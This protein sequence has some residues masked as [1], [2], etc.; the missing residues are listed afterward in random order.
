ML[1]VFM[2]IAIVLSV[3]SNIIL[4]SYKNRDFKT[5]GDVFLFNSGIS[6]VWLVVLIIWSLISGDF[7][8]SRGS[9]FFGVIYGVT[10]ALFLYFKTQSMSTGPVALTSLISNCAFLVATGFGVVYADEIVKPLQGVGMG[11]ILISLLLC[12]NPKKSE[13]KLTLKWFIYCFA[14]F[15]AGGFIGI[16]YKI[17]NK[18]DAAQEVNSMM[19]TAAIVSSVLFAVFGFIING[20]TKQQAKPKVYKKS[21]IYMLLRGIAGCIYIRMN[22]SL[23]GQIPSVIFFPVSNGANVILSTLC[24]Q[25]LFKEKLSTQQKIGIII[26]LIAIV[27]IGVA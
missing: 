7:V 5:P 9:V 3:F 27:M 15:L 8:I 22:V 2:A 12:V 11:I 4:H 25:F 6:L 17:F 26:G 18:S 19:L 14:F 10:L 13:E 16:F 20:V 23:S 21:L 24:G 1:Y